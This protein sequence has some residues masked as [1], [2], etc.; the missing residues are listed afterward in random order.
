M[1]TPATRRLLMEAGDTSF[2][3]EVRD[4]VDLDD[5]FVALDVDNNER[6]VVNGWLCC[7]SDLTS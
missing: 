5:R 4:D 3:I 1:S 2:E 7:F 6:I